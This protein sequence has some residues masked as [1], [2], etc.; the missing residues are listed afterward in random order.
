MPD[1]YDTVVGGIA[2][3]L[4]GGLLLGL[5]APVAF[6]AGVLAGALVATVFVVDALFRN[7]PLPTRN[8]AAAGILWLGF[9]VTVV[10]VG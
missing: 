5:L 6:H 10:Y 4:I 1:Y 9:L 3:S 7:P 2:A 8:V